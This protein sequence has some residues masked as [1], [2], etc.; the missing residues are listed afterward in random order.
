M[1]KI[2]PVRQRSEEQEQEIQKRSRRIRRIVLVSLVFILLTAG[3]VFVRTE[4]EREVERYR[5]SFQA[6]WAAGDYPA[7]MATYAEIQSKS[8]EKPGFFAQPRFFQVLKLEAEQ[9]IFREI[10]AVSEKLKT[11]EAP[12][13][14]E[15]EIKL[16]Q[17]VQGLSVGRLSALLQ[18]IAIDVLEMK[19]TPD[20]AKAIFVAVERTNL[21]NDQVADYRAN[22]PEL[23][24]ISPYYNEAKTLMEAN[25]DLAA[26]LKLWEVLTNKEVK[27]TGFAYEQTSAVY[28][29]LTTKL[30]PK[31]EKELSILLENNRVVTANA[32]LSTM[33]KFYPEDVSL[34][35]YEQEVKSRLPGDLLPWRGRVVHLNIYPLITNT[36]TAFDGDRWSQNADLNRLTANEFENILGQLYRQDYM[37]I[38]QS[39]LLKA[40]GTYKTITLP[41]GKKPLII[42]LLG[43]SYPPTMQEQGTAKSLVYDATENHVLCTYVNSS[44]EEV[45]EEAGDA[46]CILNRFVRE[47]PDFAFDGARG[48]IALRP[49][50]DIFGYYLNQG[51]VDA[52]QKLL[53]SY[54]MP[55]AKITADFNTAKREVEAIVKCLKEQGWD[56]ANYGFSST[57]VPDMTAEQAQGE[58]IA[59][60][61]S[62]GQIVGE[63]RIFMYPENRILPGNDERSQALQAEGYRIFGGIGPKPYLYTKGAYIYMDCQLMSGSVLRSGGLNW[64]IDSP[65][66][67]DA[68][69]TKPYS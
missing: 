35:A 13:L 9:Q 29:Q 15:E 69:R 21:I 66:A 48:T 30:K 67:Y 12:E 7:V 6:D 36:K 26:A 57:P 1:K 31:L 60:Q 59:W 42:T 11:S 39:S 17:G 58:A 63:T 4:P 25:E 38:A 53:A 43:Q 51:Q 64:L 27:K 61:N 10:D 28:R 50:Y 33:R 68:E 45:T 32:F 52:T 37:L 19:C 49:T 24:R 44:G 34:A 40:D 47:H 5:K 46:V 8:L 16:L 2:K 54:N 18:E 3:V 62:I 55:P 65:A 22:L 20:E 56:F 14:T 23:E 41:K